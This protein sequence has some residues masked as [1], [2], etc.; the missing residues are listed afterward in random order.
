[1]V[2]DGLDEMGERTKQD[3]TPKF[4]ALLSEVRKYKGVRVFLTCRSTFYKESAGED[5]IP[6]TRTITIL[7]FDDRQIETYLSH[8]PAA[9]RARL[10]A[11]L[12]RVPRL[13]ELCRTPIH[14]LLA[15]EYVAERSDVS[16]DFRL[17]DLYDAFVRKNLAIHATAN[18]GWSPRA[19]RVVVRRLAYRMFDEELVEMTTAELLRVLSE[20]LPDATRDEREETASQIRNCSFFVRAGSSFRPSHLSFLDTSSRSCS[21][22]SSTK[23]ASKNGAIVRSTRKCSTS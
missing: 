5:P 22:T 13:H 16:A 15:Q 23:G 11:L 6:A 8:T 4:A 1:L 10:A 3:E 9:V 12:E 17:I 2:L 21:S 18:P 20:E 7:P 19:R 14:L